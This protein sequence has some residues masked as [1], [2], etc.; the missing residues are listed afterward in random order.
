MHEARETHIAVCE[1]KCLDPPKGQLPISIAEEGIEYLEPEDEFFYVY[2]HLEHQSH[3]RP[4][5]ALDMVTHK[6]LTAQD[7]TRNDFRAGDKLP[8]ILP[9]SLLE[10]ILPPTIQAQG[11]V[12][13]DRK[14]CTG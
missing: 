7:L 14:S 10:M 4:R 3:P 13:N 6:L 1:K 2:L 8:M 11:Q 9:T 12:L 5:M